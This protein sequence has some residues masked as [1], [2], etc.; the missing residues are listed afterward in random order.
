MSTNSAELLANECELDT[1]LSVNTKNNLHYF[2]FT[3]V[4]T[5]L[6]ITRYLINLFFIYLLLIKTVYTNYIN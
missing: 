6:F 2:L 5:K 1:V 3:K 4:P